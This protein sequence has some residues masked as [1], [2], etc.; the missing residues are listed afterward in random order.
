[1]RCSGQLITAHRR[2]QA[3]SS[4]TQQCRGVFEPV[5]RPLETD[6]DGLRLLLIADWRCSVV[7]NGL[8]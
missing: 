7:C 4:S 1:M 5:R 3:V 8:K 6:Q 2:F